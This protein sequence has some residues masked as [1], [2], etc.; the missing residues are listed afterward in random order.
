MSNHEII[1]VEGLYRSYSGEH[2]VKGKENEIRVLN[3]LDLGVKEKE[4][5][6]IMGKSGVQVRKDCG[7]CIG[8][9]QPGM[10]KDDRY[11]YA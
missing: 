1:K 3:G 5:V 2:S 4:F 6:G 9:N 8:G 7:E 10:G 11:G